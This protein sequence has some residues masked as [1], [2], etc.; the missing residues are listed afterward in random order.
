M[1]T[2]KC[3]VRFGTKKMLVHQ[4]ANKCGNFKLVP[5]LPLPISCS[6]S[7]WQT[8]VT[9]VAEAAGWLSCH[10]YPGR[11]GK[12]GYRTATTA[13]GFPDLWL[14]RESRLVVFELKADGNHPTEEQTEWIEQLDSVEGVVARV[15]WPTDWERVVKILRE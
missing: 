15:V 11:V 8:L 7:V 4:A 10:V 3:G 12:G 6:E 13:V 14:V 2:C 9:D 1:R 5:K